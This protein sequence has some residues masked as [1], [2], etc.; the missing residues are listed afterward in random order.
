MTDFTDVFGGANIY[1]SDISYSAISLSTDV[2][3]GWPNETSSSGNL[4]TRIIDVTPSSAGKSIILP[5]A[6]MATEGETILFNNRGSYT[7]SI[8]ND[9]GTEVLGLG[10]GQSWQIYISDNSTANGIW[11]TLQYGA[12]MSSANAS[13]LAGYGLTPIASTLAQSMPVTSLNTSGYDIGASDR[14]SSIVWNGSGAGIANLPT[15][16]Q[17]GW[18]INV[19]N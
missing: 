1:P 4:A 15:S 16:I 11:K 2:T 6:T 10:S 14:A 7:V 19:R 3:L 8:K 9:G 17:N 5:D 13:E 18:F 12:S